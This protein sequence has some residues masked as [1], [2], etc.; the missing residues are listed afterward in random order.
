MAK[1]NI[2]ATMF[3]FYYDG[4]RSMTWGRTLWLLIVIKLFVMFFIL[5]L[6]FFPSFLG[7]KLEEQK[8]EFDIRMPD[9][10]EFKKE[11]LL[12]FEKEVTGFYVSGHPLEKYEGIWKKHITNVTADFALDEETGHSRVTDGSKATVGGMITE[13]TIKYTRKNQTMAFLTLEDLLGTVEIVVFPRDYEKNKNQLM[14]DEKVFISGRVSV[15]EDKPSKLICER[16]QNFKE[17]HKEVWIQFPNM[18]AYQSMERE[19]YNV[20]RESDG[21]DR[22]VIYVREPK[23]V[24]RLSENWTVNAEEELIQKLSERFGPENV[25]TI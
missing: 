25:K 15:E 20:L 13:K 4:F 8:Q 3:R 16:I 11:V 5:K 23:A 14:E 18:E 10:P 21:K 17:I 19:L 6:F 9:I 22:V 12:N 24:K 2:I 7:E 1:R